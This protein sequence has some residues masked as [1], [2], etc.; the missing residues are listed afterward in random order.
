MVL[1]LIYNS[2]EH[3]DNLFILADP[4]TFKDEKHEVVVLYVVGSE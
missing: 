4:L 1:C 3:G 2:D